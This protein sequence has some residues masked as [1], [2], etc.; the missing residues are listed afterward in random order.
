MQTIDFRRLMYTEND[1]NDQV[2]LQ[3]SR[4]IKIKA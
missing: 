2:A 4:S 3:T 1:K